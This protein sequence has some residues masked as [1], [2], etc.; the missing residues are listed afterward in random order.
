MMNEVKLN[1]YL[2]IYAKEYNQKPTTDLVNRIMDIP[3][4]VEQNP[5][6]SWCLS[7]WFLFLIPRIS[8]LTAACIMGLYVGGLGNTANAEDELFEA[9]FATI[10]DIN[11]VADE[12]L[13]FVEDVVQ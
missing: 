7:D 13:I 3:N 8:G 6:L 12:D 5:K 10:E 11:L 1:E 2:N 9:D 4:S